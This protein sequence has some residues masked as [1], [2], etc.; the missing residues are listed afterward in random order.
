MRLH[1]G[2]IRPAQ[3]ALRGL[4]VRQTKRQ[5]IWYGRRTHSEQLGWCATHLRRHNSAPGR[6]H[7]ARPTRPHGRRPPPPPYFRRPNL[8]LA[9][10]A[11]GA[12]RLGPSPRLVPT[13][14]APAAQHVVAVADVA[15][16]PVVRPGTLLIAGETA[17][18]MPSLGGC[19]LRSTSCSTSS[20]TSQNLRCAKRVASQVLPRVYLECAP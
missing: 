7:T 2:T 20:S 3:R 14:R 18:L 12:P 11:F 15:L 4:S 6:H 13:A 16:A 1:G 19:R 5:T 9:P 17:T 10:S 8:L